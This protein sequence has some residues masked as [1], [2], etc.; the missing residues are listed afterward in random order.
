[1]ERVNEDGITSV[2]CNHTRVVGLG[3]A[4]VEDVVEL[5]TA[6]LS[7]VNARLEQEKA[8][9]FEIVRKM[10]VQEVLAHGRKGQKVPD[11]KKIDKA[12]KK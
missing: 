10:P 11:M 2:E 6:L 9:V 3:S 8:K 12:R 1:M 5:T 4:D 7:Y